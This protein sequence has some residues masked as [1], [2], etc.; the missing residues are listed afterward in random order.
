MAHREHDNPHGELSILIMSWGQFI[1]HDITLA[2]PPRGKV[3]LSISHLV[4]FKK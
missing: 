1:D 2:A 4:N 3:T